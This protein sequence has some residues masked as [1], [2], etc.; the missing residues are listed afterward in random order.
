MGAI[1]MFVYQST[2]SYLDKAVFTANRNTGNNNIQN[3]GNYLSLVSSA[4]IAAFV[5]KIVATIVTYPTQVIRTG[6]QDHRS[7]QQHQLQQQQLMQQ[8]QQLNQNKNT[9]TFRP[10]AYKYGIV[11]ATRDVYKHKGFMGFYRGLSMQMLR[12]SVGNVI[13][14]NCWEAFKLFLERNLASNT[15]NTPC[16]N[17]GNLKI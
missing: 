7:L 10:T 9:T 8:Q 2:K 4:T 11:Q 13:V 17:K 14:F 16:I 15:S 12:A 1:V 3:D 6:L 5:S